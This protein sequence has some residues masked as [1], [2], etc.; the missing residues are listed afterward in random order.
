MNGEYPTA[1]IASFALVVVH[2]PSMSLDPRLYDR[3]VD[4][5]MYIYKDC[6]FIVL[7]KKKTRTVIVSKHSQGC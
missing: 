5:P 7:T 6:L 4:G 2:M 3:A 1:D